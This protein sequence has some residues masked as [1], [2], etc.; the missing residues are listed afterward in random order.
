MAATAAALA[1]ATLGAARQAGQAPEP[2][3]RST[4]SGVYT[5]AQASRGEKTFANV[6]MGCHTTATYSTP[7]FVRKW[8]GRPLGELFGQISETMP[9]DFPGSLQPA[10][11]AQ[12]IAYLLKINRMPAGA[13]D[14]PAD[15][16][17]LDRIRFEIPKSGGGA[18]RP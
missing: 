5:D 16:D 11:Y 6:C 12:V 1:V 7:A 10:E 9:E 17:A 2:P 4:L 18:L 14:L 8:D 3:A 13:E 15:Q